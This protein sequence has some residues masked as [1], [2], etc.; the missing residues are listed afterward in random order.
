MTGCPAKLSEEEKYYKER[1]AWAEQNLNYESFSL[2]SV[3]Y[4]IFTGNGVAKEWTD[5]D[6]V[7][8]SSDNVSR[9]SLAMDFHSAEEFVFRTFSSEVPTIKKGEWLY[10]S[11][12]YERFLLVSLHDHRRGGSQ[13]G[14]RSRLY[15]N[16][17]Q[18]FSQEQGIGDK[19]YG[20]E[21][22][23][24]FGQYADQDVKYIAWNQYRNA[25]NLDNRIVCTGK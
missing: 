20:K 25:D 12:A 13:Q 3:D 7:I 16:T 18:R 9:E 5:Y 21:K 6:F 15:G 22:P 24:D 4:N 23:E 1:D 19:T 10:A 8:L 17:V 11:V 14:L 2:Y